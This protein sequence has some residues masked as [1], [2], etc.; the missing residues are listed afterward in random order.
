MADGQTGVRTITGEKVKL[1]LNLIP[2]TN[3]NSGQITDLSVKPTTIKLLEIT[4]G[5]NPGV[6]IVV[7][8]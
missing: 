3:I 2:H 1:D 4:R 5:E 6:P 7:Q 8:Q